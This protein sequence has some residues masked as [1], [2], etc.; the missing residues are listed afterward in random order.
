MNCFEDVPD[1]NHCFFRNFKPDTTLGQRQLDLAIE[2][3]FAWSDLSLNVR[4][5]VLN[6]FNYENVD[7][8]ET[9]RG[10]P[11]E[12]NAAFG[13]PT[14]WRQPTRTF[15]LSFSLEWR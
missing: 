3:G 1:L 6:V 8:Y 7:R 9:Y 12:P 10:N 15:K 11:N 4:A 2:K 13:N 14:A 5:D